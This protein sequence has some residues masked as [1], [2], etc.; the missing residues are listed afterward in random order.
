M[1]VLAI[2]IGSSRIKALLAGWDGRLTEVRSA[3]TPRRNAEPGEASYPVDEVVAAVERLI[4]ESSVFHDDAIDTLVFSC[5]GTAMAPI[6]ADGQPLAPA[7]APDDRRPR[8]DARGLDSLGLNHD[9]L[10]HRTGS[11]PAVPSFL[12]HA[13]WWRSVHPEV[14]DRTHRFRSLRGCLMAR[15]CGADVEDHSW[16]SRTMLYDLDAG[17]WSSP[18]IEAVGLSAQLFPPLAPSTV[19]LSIDPDTAQRLGLAS[20]ARAVL[21]AMDNGCA[22]LGASGPGQAGLVDIVGT[23]EHLAG[24]APLDVARAILQDADGVIHAYPLDGRY[25]AMTR[26]LLGELL[27]VISQRADRELGTLLDGLSAEPTGSTVAA[28][29]GA[30]TAELDAGRPPAEV[31]QGVLESAAATLAGFADAWSA[32]GLT[33]EPVTVVGGGAAHPKVLQLKAA[34]L[35]RSLVTLAS[36]EAAAIGALR[37]AAMGVRGATETEAGQLFADPV[38]QTITPPA[39]VLA[40]QPEGRHVS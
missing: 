32:Q 7:L 14:L 33:A 37:L 36:D 5:L 13:W 4:V 19:A 21:G 10:R 34:L 8:A 6:A 15:L 28:D 26:V 24:A 23:Y 35:G 38:A 25:I 27:R 16:A 3:R 29:P 30:V 18:I 40:H 17:D 2:D 9:E 11:D 1:S 31:L 22:H 20:D 12:W 39:T